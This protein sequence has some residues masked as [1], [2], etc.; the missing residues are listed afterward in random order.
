MNRLRWRATRCGTAPPTSRSTMLTAQATQNLIDDTSAGG[1]VFAT[2]F[3]YVWIGHP[4]RRGGAVAS[5]RVF[6]QDRTC[7]L[8]LQARRGAILPWAALSRFP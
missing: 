3:S 4:P 8:P 2:H 5:S 1:R 7:A 6:F